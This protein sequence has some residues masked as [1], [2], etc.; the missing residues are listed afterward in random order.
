MPKGSSRIEP[1]KT[2]VLG[3]GNLLLGD[4]GAGVRVIELLRRS[5]RLENVE[6][7]DGG[8]SGFGLLEFF[9]KADLLVVVDAARDGRPP[10][11][12][13]RV[14]PVFDPAYPPVLM[15]HDIGLKDLL[16]AATVLGKKPEVVLFTISVAETERLTLD[17]SP[18]VDQGIRNAA[19][20]I[21]DFLRALQR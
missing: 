12:V 2:V 9:A 7:V 5:G 3:L 15:P 18:P 19:D 17:L 8:T 21:T 14:S 10:G 1:Q 11:T 4:E 13:A 6:L 20:L 16:D